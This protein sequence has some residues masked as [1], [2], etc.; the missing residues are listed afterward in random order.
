MAKDCRMTVPPREPQQNNKSHRKEPQKKTW[1]RKQNQ[2]SSEECTLTLQSKKNKCGWYVENG[3]SKHM[4][5]DKHR[6][7]TLIKERDGS[8]TFKNYDSNK[9]IGKGTIRIGNN[10]TKEENVL[11]VED[12]KHNLLSVS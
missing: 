1:I 12:M 4:T 8:V 5:G 10:N 6:F 2:Y 7:L 9:I 3:C 11:L